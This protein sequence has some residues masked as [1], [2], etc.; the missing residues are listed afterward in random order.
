LCNLF[1]QSSPYQYLNSKLNTIHAT[2]AHTASSRVPSRYPPE[3]NGMSK[4][5]GC[6]DIIRLP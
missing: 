6:L 2:N 1:H 5:L 3:V 4:R